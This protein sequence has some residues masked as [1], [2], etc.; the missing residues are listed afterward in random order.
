VISSGGVGIIAE[1][2]AG[3]G[4]RTLNLSITLV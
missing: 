2:V 1:G 3:R 4:V